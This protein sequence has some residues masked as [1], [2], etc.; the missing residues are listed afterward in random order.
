[1]QDINNIRFSYASRSS[2]PVL[3]WPDRV[4][5]QGARRCR[6][7]APATPP[8]RRR[9][10]AAHRNADRA[11][12]RQDRAG[13]SRCGRERRILLGMD[14]RMLKDLGLNGIAYA[15]ASRPFLG[16]A[17]R[18]LAPLSCAA[19]RRSSGKS[20]TDQGFSP[21][22][23]PGSGRFDSDGFEP[24]DL[25]EEIKHCNLPLASLLCCSYS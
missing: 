17:G 14:D 24:V 7:L 25:S 4:T 23:T 6:T 12:A 19:P 15:E 2:R 20:S 3:P 11:S 9:A 16:R 10:R 21:K 18:A 1:M 8:P 22:A 13:P 5:K